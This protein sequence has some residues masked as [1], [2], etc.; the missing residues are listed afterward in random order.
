MTGRHDEQRGQ[1]AD[2]AA[3]RNDSELQRRP[4]MKDVADRLGVSRQLVSLVMR[5]VPGPSAESRD[6]ILAAADELGYRPTQVGMAPKPSPK[7]R[8]ALA[9]D[10]TKRSTTPPYTTDLE[11]HQ[12]RCN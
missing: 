7:Q 12:G 4:T 6:R 3:G 1:L 11:K 2:N 10:A 8:F 5:D 9:R